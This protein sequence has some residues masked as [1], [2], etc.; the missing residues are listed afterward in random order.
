M[1]WKQ[2]Y[3]TEDRETEVELRVY[4]PN[5]LSWFWSA[6]DPDTEQSCV[7]TLPGFET[8]EAAMMAAEAWYQECW[9]PNFK[10]TGSR[11]M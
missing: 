5:G 9:L 3:T 11:E 7:S 2:E 10:L 4:N 6:F 1:E 8:K